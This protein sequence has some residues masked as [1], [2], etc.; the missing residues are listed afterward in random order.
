MRCDWKPV[1]QKQEAVEAAGRKHLP[2]VVERPAERS[3][4]MICMNKESLSVPATT[5][6]RYL[7]AYPFKT[8]EF[9]K[10]Y[11]Q[12]RQEMEGKNG[13]LKNPQMGRMAIPGE[14]RFRGWAKQFLTLLI[15][16]VAY[17]LL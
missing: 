6:A 11:R 12:G 14:R 13:Y 5:F 10:T 7:S 1:T 2:L 16:L 9:D 15:K 8:P 3:D 17:P 4:S